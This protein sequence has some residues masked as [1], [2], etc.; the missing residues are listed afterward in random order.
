MR[1]ISLDCYI[2]IK[3][4]KQEL[5]I[6]NYSQKIAAGKMFLS[7]AEEMFS[8]Q[9][10]N[11]QWQEYRK[12]KQVQRLFNF[13]SSKVSPDLILLSKC[14]S[15]LKILLGPYLSLGTVYVND[16]YLIPPIYDAI[17]I[18]VEGDG[19]GGPILSGGEQGQVLGKLS[20]QDQDVGWLDFG[21]S[22]SYIT[23]DSGGILY[24]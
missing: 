14:I 20:D 7:L 8:G 16:I 13:E 15:L 1:G 4:T 6:L 11:Y 21:S 22:F 24:I 5:V 3:M 9:E 23:P 19:D 18:K 2:I 12:I 10:Y 17:T